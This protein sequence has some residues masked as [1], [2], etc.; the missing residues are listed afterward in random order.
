M[1]PGG[2]A[3]ARV[4]LKV[5]KE[6]VDGPGPVRGGLNVAQGGELTRREFVGFVNI[7]ET[8]QVWMPLE[9][10]PAMRLPVY[11]RLEPTSDVHVRSADSAVTGPG[12]A[13]AAVIDVANPS[14]AAGPIE[15]FLWFGDDGPDEFVAERV[16]VRH[17]GARLTRDA[18]GVALLEFAATYARPDATP[19]GIGMGVYLDTDDDGDL[20]WLVV[21]ADAEVIFNGELSGEWATVAAPFAEG[22]VV[23]DWSRAVA[24]YYGDVRLDGAYTVVRVRPQTLG[25]PANPSEAPRPISFFFAVED[26]LWTGEDPEVVDV[27]PGRAGLTAPERLLRW[28]PGEPGLAVPGW[29]FGLPGHSATELR[30]ATELGRSQMM[31]PPPPG[32]VLIYP[33]ND[34][35]TAV[36]EALPIS[37]PERFDVPLYRVWLPSAW[38]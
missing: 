29:T 21:G 6:A 31:V 12:P 38:R 28:A 13:G 30:A 36:A 18:E 32:I 9:G 10:R 23:P 25:L 1:S 33:A 24:E 20:D 8:D 7:T 11:G 3:D 17:I 4:A 27:A 14:G 35:L 37:L 16:D 22:S 2:V 15:T 5:P 19:V 26:R 34:Q